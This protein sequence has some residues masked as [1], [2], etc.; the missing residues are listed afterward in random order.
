MYL[1]YLNVILCDVPRIDPRRQVHKH[2]LQLSAHTRETPGTCNMEC[3]LDDSH[4][5]TSI[6]WE[7]QGNTKAKM[8]RIVEFKN[9]FFGGFIL[10]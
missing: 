9:S 10:E 2:I 7:Y 3:L 5:M 4:L 8:V 6:S 1:I